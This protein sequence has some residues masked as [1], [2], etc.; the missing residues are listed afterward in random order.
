[1]STMTPTRRLDRPAGDLP[2]RMLVVALEA[3]MGV[4]GVYGG[5][6]L[7][8]DTFGLPSEWIDGT[9]FDTWFWPGVLLLLLVAIPGLVAATVEALGRRWIVPWSLA[10]G[11]GLVLW[12]LVQITMVPS[13]FL[14]PV[15][16]ACGLVIA[17]A[18]AVRLALRRRQAPAARE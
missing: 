3:L 18:S 6:S 8:R 14:Q 4:G 11:L 13:F 5:V 7:M 17:A 2:L 16:A 12:I 1:V 15:V 9:P 10:Y